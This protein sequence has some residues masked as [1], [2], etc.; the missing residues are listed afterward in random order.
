MNRHLPA[1]FLLAVF[2]YLGGSAQ[3]SILWEISGNQ[4]TTTSY[5]MG[6]LKFISDEEF[7]IPREAQDR[8]LK[9]NV[10]AIED[11]VD[12]R[13]QHELN[14]AVHFPEGQ[15]LKSVLSDADYDSVQHFFE[16]EFQIPGDVF[17]SEYAK[18]IPLA[19]IITMTR[20]SLGDRVTFYDIELF[21]MA[22]EYKLK[23]VTLEEIEREAE[24]IRKFSTKDQVSALMRGIANFEKQKEEFNKL[25]KAY[26]NGDPAEIFQYTLHPADNNEQF[27]EAF[28]YNRNMEWLPKIEALI[29]TQSTFIAVGLSHLEGGHG[30]ITLLQGK[31][32]TL[33]PVLLN[34]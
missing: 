26:P 6:T 23:T 1:V 24:A 30:L 7:F 4:L 21:K 5:L 12:H 2:A 29:R 8:L 19:L 34:R 33:T 27:V 31:G 25:V 11:P 14:K 13:A 16:N 3:T 28:Y 9:S 22:V 18:M 15:N 32:Y 10:F 20:L 17:E